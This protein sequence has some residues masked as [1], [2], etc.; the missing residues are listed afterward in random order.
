MISPITDP[1][2]QAVG[3]VRVSTDQQEDRYGPARQRRDIER[4]A[5]FAGLEIVHWHEEAVSGA[6]LERYNENAYYDLA[7]AHPGLNFIFSTAS[8]VGRHV[9]IIVGIAR[10]L[11]KLK[12]GVWVAGIGDLRR[13]RNWKE[14]LREAVDAES[15]YTGIIRQLTEGK[16]DKAQRGQWAQGRAPWGYRIVRDARG[17]STGL[18]ID[19]EAAAVVRRV[20][21]L[22][23]HHGG[24]VVTAHQLNAE[25][26]LTATGQPWTAPAVAAL[27]RNSRYTGRAEFYGH[28]VTFE[29]I[30]PPELWQD[31][32]R[33]FVAR[34]KGERKGHGP[35][36][37]TGIARCA[38]CGGALS[39][40]VSRGSGRGVGRYRYYH[41]WRSVG[42]AARWPPCPHKKYYRLE[43]LEAAAWDAVTGLLTQPERVA[44]LLT[45][46]ENSAPGNPA[47]VT[48][49]REEMTGLLTRAARYDLPD[50]VVQ[51]ALEPLRDELARLEQV[52]SPVPR[53]L[54]PNLARTCAALAAAMEHL[55]RE[56]RRGVLED[57]RIKLDVE[58]GGAVQV[59]NFSLPRA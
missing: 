5:A 37:L 9:E 44:E 19:P 4:E 26:L 39:A 45:P 18:E 52:G 22:Y 30:I 8:R 2:R 21:E 48:A 34:R 31:A 36:M 33:Q 50:D 14:F 20:F 38:T 51:A 7:R 58:P 29:P 12:A 28:V 56:Q 40:A 59:T 55:E 42:R 35:E 53:Q 16:R 3:A 24:N 43:D 17:V 10:E 6:K 23:A 13:P 15:E 25:G 54:P 32:Q 57:L 11:L 41:C 47:R 49:I 27:V 46:T 1:T